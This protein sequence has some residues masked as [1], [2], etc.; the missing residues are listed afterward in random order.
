SDEDTDEAALERAWAAATPGSARTA[1][2]TKRTTGLSFAFSEFDFQVPRNIACEG[3]YQVRLHFE[4]K[5]HGSVGPGERYTRVIEKHF[6]A[7]HHVLA[8]SFDIRQMQFRLPAAGHFEQ[9]EYDTDYTLLGADITRGCDSSEAGTPKVWRE[10]VHIHLDLGRGAA[11]LS[12]GAVML[13]A[14]TITAAL[15]SPA[16]LVPST[17][18]GNGTVVVRDAAG[19]LRQMQAPSALADIVTLSASAYEVRFYTA[20]DVGVA[21]A[22]TGIF[23]VSGTPYVVFKFENPASADPASGRL[24][25]TETRGSLVRVTEFAHDAANNTWSFTQGNGLRK[26]STAVE[27]LGGGLRRETSVIYDEN[28]A[29]VSKMDREITVFPWGEETTREVL[30]PAGAAL[31][32]VSEFCTTEGAPGY[33]LLKQRT[34]PDGSWERHTYDATGRPLRVVRPF[35]NS[36]VGDPDTS[37]RVTD[38]TYG[39][40]VDADGDGIDEELTTTVETTLGTETGRTYTVEWSKPVTLGG[41]DFA[42]RSDIRCTA[43]GAAW[44]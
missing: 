13:D 14:D 2:R 9:M 18:F 21:D 12:A 41:E 35:L 38:H 15:Y 5:P 30:D 16:A 26:E 33:A 17:P 34:R 44:N 22:E 37:S 39:A 23:A 24:R 1:Y 27:E 29:V 28:D 6:A 25:L 42:R 32:T 3:S 40:L 43:A 20:A 11:G 8:G 7:G 10:S 36:T 31:A 19:A 4:K